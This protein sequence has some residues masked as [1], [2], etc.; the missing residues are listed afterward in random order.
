MLSNEQI[1]SFRLALASYN[2]CGGPVTDEDIGDVVLSD[3]DVVATRE[4]IEDFFAARGRKLNR[5]GNRPE[6]PSEL[7]TTALGDV[8]VGDAA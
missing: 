8:Y 5:F 1:K 2:H 4:T 3:D 7:N 6:K